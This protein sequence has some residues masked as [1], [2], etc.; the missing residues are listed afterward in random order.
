MAVASA[1]FAIDG[2][3]QAGL[4]RHWT[5]VA[6]ELAAIVC[7]VAESVVGFR[8]KAP[9]G[10]LSHAGMALILAGGL[11]GSQLGADSYHKIYVGQEEHLSFD[12]ALEQFETEY[13]PDGATPRQFTSTLLLDGKIIEASV[14][15]PARYKGWRIYQTGLGE[16][17]SG[18]YSVLRVVRSPLLPLLALGALML[19]AGAALSLKNVRRSKK[20]IVAE[21]VLACIF[22][23]ASLVEINF[24]TLPPALRSP[25]F[26]PHLAAYMLAYALLAT[27]VLF[28]RREL[29]SVLFSAASSLLLFGMLCGAFWAQQAWGS[30]WDWDPKEC[31]AAAT[32][33]LTLSAVHVPPRNKSLMV[34][35]AVL[36]FLAMNMTWYGVNLLPSSTASLHTYN[37]LR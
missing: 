26:V 13:Y 19:V 3:W 23:A 21:I 35:L 2:T 16:D 14:N 33:L 15:H 34:I 4:H 27:S 10:V 28:I 6:M 9:S 12:I 32:W 5:F 24:G 11:A 20:V 8:K 30:C 29:F 36:A 1:L 37:V 25:W 17:G 22:A 7:L 18:R 31:W